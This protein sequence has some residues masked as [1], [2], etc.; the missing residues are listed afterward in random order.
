MTDPTPK[1]KSKWRRL[2]GWLVKGLLLIVLLFLLLTTFV[3]PF[4]AA[5]VFE[6]PF[7]II[8]GWFWF[9]DQNVRLMEWD[10]WRCVTG[11]V[12]LGIAVACLHGV[13]GALKKRIRPAGAV[14]RWRWTGAMALTMLALGLAGIAV[15]AMASQIAWL[16]REPKVELTGHSHAM[17]NSSNAHQVL[18]LV[19]DYVYEHDGRYPI[20]LEEVARWAVETDQLLALGKLFFFSTERDATP[21][22]WLYFGKGLRDPIPPQTVLLASPRTVRGKRI[23]AQGSR[24]VSFVDEAKFAELLGAQVARE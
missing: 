21:E 9:I 11:L 17:W 14:W 6:I 8:A 19:S 7:R 4:G 2:M 5:W 1:V 18:W 24:E 15:T 10:L 3:I 20:D 16:V 12:S 23:V 13:I 22:P